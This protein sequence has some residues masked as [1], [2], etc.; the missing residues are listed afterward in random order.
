MLCEML[1]AFWHALHDTG[2]SF[3]RDWRRDLSDPLEKRQTGGAEVTQDTGHGSCFSPVFSDRD[4]KHVGDISMKLAAEHSAQVATYQL[5]VAEGSKVVHPALFT[6]HPT[7]NI[8]WFVL[9]PSQPISTLES[10][11]IT[12]QTSNPIAAPSS[13]GTL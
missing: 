6:A 4:L 3:G 5:L 11:M 7:C 2:Q 10:C 1:V 12:F 8:H 9:H 13:C